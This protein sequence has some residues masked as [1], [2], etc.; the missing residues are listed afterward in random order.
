MK[1][2]YKEEVEDTV[3]S[4]GGGGNREITLTDISATLNQYAGKYMVVTEGNQNGT[5]SLIASN[6][7]ADP[8]VLTVSDDQNANL[9]ADKIN[10]QTSASTPWVRISA[11]V[12]YPRIA[13]RNNSY[14]IC[15]VILRDFEGALFSTWI[16]RDF[17][18]MK[19]EDDD[20]NILFRGFLVN[21]KFT[22]KSLILEL[23]GFAILLDW[24]PFYKNYI[25]AEG[26]V[27]TSPASS[28]LTVFHDD[29]EDE[30]YDSPDEDFTWTANFW[31]TD[32]DVGLL[33]VD[34]SNDVTP[35]PWTCKVNP[36]TG[37]GGNY[38]RGDKDSLDAVND[39]DTYDITDNSVRW[40]ATVTTTDIGDSDISDGVELHQI[41][42]N[43]RIGMKCPDATM[44]AWGCD[45]QVNYDGV[46]ITKARPRFYGG[47]GSF[48]FLEG[49]ITLTG[50]N[51]E[52]AKYLD[53]TGANYDE[54]KGIKFVMYT[55]VGGVT[56]YL[57]IDLCTATIY[58]YAYDIQPIMET[59]TGSAAS[60]I[61]CSSV[62]WN[63]T[64][65]I[66]T[67]NDCGGDSCNG[68]KWK[69]GQNTVQI[70][71]DI[72]AEIE[73][74]IEIIGQEITSP[75]DVTLRP[76]GDSAVAW[77]HDDSGG[78]GSHW[79][80]IEEVI[81]QPNAGDGNTIYSTTDGQED[82]FNMETTA[83]GG[84]NIV[85]NITLWTYGQLDDILS[86]CTA[87]IQSG[88]DWLGTKFPI[89]S[90]DPIGGASYGWKSVTW[91]N[92]NINQ[93]NLDSLKV[94]YEVVDPL[95]VGGTVRIDLF[96]IVITYG[97]YNPFT[98]YMARLFRGTH[99]IDGLNAVCKLEGADWIEDYINYR[100]KLV[101]PTTYED[102]SIVLTQ[103]E[104]DHDWEFED[105]C[106]QVRRVDV[107]GQAAYNIHEW[108]EDNSVTG[109]IS[110]QIIDESI[111]NNADALTMAQNELDKLSTKRPSIK[112]PLI[113]IY[114]LLQLG[115]SANL[116]MIRPTVAAADYPI[117]M[118]ERSRHGKTGIQTI[119]YAGLGETKDDERIWSTISKIAYLA[120]KGLSDRL[121]STP[122]S[123]GANISWNDVAGA[124]SGAVAAVNAA[125]DYIKNDANDETTGD[126]TVANLIT[127]GLVDGVDV[128]VRDHAKYTDSDARSATISD[129]DYTSLWEAITNNAPT[130]H[131]VYDAIEALRNSMLGINFFLHQDA[132]ADVGGYKL[133]DIAFPD[134]AKT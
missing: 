89:K 121:I 39:D 34:N 45:I 110:K 80:D 67:D 36:T 26:K 81:V 29:N 105:K 38:I 82:I 49:I 2:H 109:R 99:A 96:Y 64:G 111:T 128:S 71:S 104:Y 113:G 15:T 41:D 86:N 17:T 11:L 55:D 53:K 57:N 106:N 1:I 37:D 54:L 58:H 87:D 46:Y 7:A 132:S 32:R 78:D 123:A 22:T 61:T 114:P 14:G 48:I 59:I 88:S 50:D 24:I 28:I 95:T 69:I 130:K 91:S 79:K 9:A 94:K 85:T 90:F 43:W 84:S 115:T 107:W 18:P 27:K 6:T 5:N 44:F 65:V 125:D 72:A 40:G 10:I 4:V 83:M 3:A 126:L 112:I 68:D 52:L 62:I 134:D 35:I 116:T 102:S 42:I 108:V 25:L 100:I 19:V 74:P 117:R 23:V 8:T 16:S 129:L 120:N 97:V 92:L 56:G 63:Q 77:S 12:D 122:W 124:N 30:V 131:V 13:S 75:T 21:K 20:S 47:I 119:I 98:K 118:I 127:A 101:K 93:A 51:T 70:V 60:T 31:V 76:N 66:G 73:I 103:D 33:I 133:L